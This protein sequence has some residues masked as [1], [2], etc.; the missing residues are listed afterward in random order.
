M[1]TELGITPGG[2]RQLVQAGHQVLVEIGAGEG[3]GFSDAEYETSGAK[4]VS[5]SAE[6]WQQFSLWNIQ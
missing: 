2:M 5:T 3:S 6:A 1:N 4:I